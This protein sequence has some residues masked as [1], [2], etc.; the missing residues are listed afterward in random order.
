MFNTY[1]DLINFAKE[2]NWNK[3]SYSYL[4]LHHILPKNMGGDDSPD[5]L[6]FLKV[7]EH[8]EAHYLLAMEHK[9]NKKIYYAN[10]NSAY[11]I[12]YGKTAGRSAKDEEIKKWLQDPENLLKIEEIKKLNIGKKVTNRKKPNPKVHYWMEYKFR[13]PSSITEKSIFKYLQLGYTQIKDCPICHLPNSNESF[14]CSKEHEI[15]YMNLKKENFKKLR[16]EQS[17]EM[18]KDDNTRDKIINSLTGIEKVSNNCWITNGIDSK[19]IS[20]NELNDYLSKGW[21]LGRSNIVG[22]PQSEEYKQ[23][24]S[25]RRK[26]SCY[27]YNDE[28]DCKEIQK[29]ELDEYL[30]KG[31]KRGRRVTYSRKGIKQP[32]MAWVNNGSEIKKIR[33][34]NLDE[35]LNNGW[36][37]GRKF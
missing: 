37:K 19:M 35:Y 15:E 14:A 26:N 7:S 20:K 4:E 21:L 1:N 18:W 16:S 31:W 25:E 5:N 6:V 36:K 24:V 27:V 34:E 11:L 12:I 17:K 30:V 10:L 3:N 13:Y 28:I 9:W 33:R 29:S 32:P 23:K 22:K 8:I 2:R